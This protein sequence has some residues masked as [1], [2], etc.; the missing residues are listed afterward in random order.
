MTFRWFYSPDS[1]EFNDV[2]HTPLRNYQKIYLLRIFATASGKR[3][4]L[5]KPVSLRCGLTSFSSNFRSHFGFVN[6]NDL[7]GELPDEEIDELFEIEYKRWREASKEKKAAY[8]VNPD[9]LYER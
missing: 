8:S 5:P 3:R 7:V 4:I 1:A 2:D 6:G 9:A